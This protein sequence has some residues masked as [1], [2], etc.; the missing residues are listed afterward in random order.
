MLTAINREKQLKHWRRNWKI[1]LIE[2]ANPERGDLYRTL[3]Q[4]PAP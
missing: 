4:P 2:Q 3:T 1:K